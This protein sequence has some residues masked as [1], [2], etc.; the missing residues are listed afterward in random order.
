MKSFFLIA[1]VLLSFVACTKQNDGAPTDAPP[2]LDVSVKKCQTFSSSRGQL[3]CC[4]DS[5]LDDS[6]CPAY[7]NCGWPGRAVARFT[8]TRNNEHHIGVMQLGPG[9]PSGSIYPNVIF[10]MGYNIG[11]KQ[12]DPYPGIKPY[13]YPDYKA[14]LLVTE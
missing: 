3:V 12:L 13:N 14:G 10:V 11:F 9:S 4:L 2:N 1:S 7:A 8:F 6:R 5:V